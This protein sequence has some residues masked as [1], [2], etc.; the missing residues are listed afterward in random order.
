MGV[1][2][3]KFARELTVETA[4]DVLARARELGAAGKQVVELEIGD[5]PFPSTSTAKQAGRQ[6]IADDHS[7]Y[8]PSAGLPQ[9]RQAAAE[10]V[11][12][13]YNVDCTADN[14]VVGPG[15]KV[16]ELLFCETF[17]GPGDGVLVF[18]P[19]FPTYVPNI[20]RRGGRVWFS[21]LKQDRQFRPNLEDVARFLE[22][23][24]RPKAVFL[25]SP[26]N[27]TGGVA[28]PE[29]LAGLAE[30]VRGREVAVLSDEP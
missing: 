8:C 4:F 26:H 7:H 12:G 10:Y 9:F 15:A 6:A 29:D 5:S 13:Q 11:R 2:F 17:V 21:A 22:T 30:L 3:S 27:P 16:F 28:E 23:D 19:Y 14:V 24:P 18:S 1:S 20:A 25:N